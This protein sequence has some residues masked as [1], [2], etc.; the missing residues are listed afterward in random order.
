ME[1]FTFIQTRVFRN[2]MQIHIKIKINMCFS[3]ENAGVDQR[4][5]VSQD[6]KTPKAAG[7][8]N[9]VQGAAVALRQVQENLILQR[10]GLLSEIGESSSKPSSRKLFQL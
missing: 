5:A 3:L 7:E 2:E 1:T 6:W 9:S 10:G 4:K 8:N